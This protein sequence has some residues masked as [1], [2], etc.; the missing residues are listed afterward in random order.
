MS[1]L[2]PRLQAALKFLEK[3]T[4]TPEQVRGA[5]VLAARAAGISDSALREA[6]YVCFVLSTMDRLADAFQFPVPDGR[7]LR[8][9]AWIA[10]NFGYRGF[11]A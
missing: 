2:D 6:L 10:A 9:Y 3:L 11:S 5:D 1:G 4:L 7:I 8:R